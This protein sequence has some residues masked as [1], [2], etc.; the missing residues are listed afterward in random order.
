MKAQRSIPSQ[1][2]KPTQ[3]L[4]LKKRKKPS[5]Q[6]KNLFKSCTIYCI[7][8]IKFYINQTLNVNKK[9]ILSNIKDDTHHKRIYKPKIS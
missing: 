8:D 1:Q 4:S 3:K 7:H 2:Y 9:I 5:R 6:N